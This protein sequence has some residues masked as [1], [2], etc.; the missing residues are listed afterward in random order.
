MMFQDTLIMD[1]SI[2]MLDGTSHCLRVNPQ[3]TLG[4]L[5]IHIQ[6]KVGVSPERQKLVFDNGT[7]VHLSDDSQQLSRY[8]LQSGSQLSLLLT[9]PTTIQVF[10]RNE[11]GQMSTYNI[12]P[13]ETV[14]AF[15]EK[16]KCR[17]GVQVSQQRLLHQSREM[18][19]GKLS[20]YSVKDMSTID[21]MLRLRGG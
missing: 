12:K 14:S 15:K 5:K 18:Q 2:I 17:E 21:M 19:D 6:S 16:V 3:D 13:D 10:V 7:R 20:D 9:Q 8:G 4:S 1:I 11:K